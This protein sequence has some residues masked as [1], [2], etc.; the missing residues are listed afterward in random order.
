MLRPIRMKKVHAIV[1]ED[2]L[3]PLMRELKELGIIH[4]INVHEEI[5][6]QEMLK[7]IGIEVPPSTWVRYKTSGLL[8][9]INRILDIL[10]SV[11][12][13]KTF[14]NKIKKILE[15]KEIEKIPIKETS[16]LELF[17]GFE[18]KFEN[19]EKEVLKT[20]SKLD[21][22]REERSDILTCQEVLSILE[23]FGIGPKYLEGF[24]L[25]YLETGTVPKDQLN[26]LEP[27]LKEATE[28]FLYL[29]SG[30]VDKKTKF[31]II[32][33]LYE[34]E[35][36][37]RKILRARGFES[38]SIPRKICDLE[39]ED[40]E[41]FLEESISHI[42]VE[43]DKLKEELKRIANVNEKELL[44]MK[45][46]LEIE[47]NLDEI[48]SLFGK[49]TK[50]Y[51]I[52][53]WVP[54][55]L[56]EKLKEIFNNITNGY[57]IIRIDEPKK[58]DN[59]PT[60]LSNPPPIKPVEI[61]TETYGL[62]GYDK[63]DPTFFM[64]ISFPFMYGLMFGDVG[65]GLVIAILGFLLGFYFKFGEV[66][67]KFGKIMLACGIMGTL[68]GL[69]YGSVF[70]LEI[71]E[72]L[73]LR[74][75]ESGTNLV[76][77]AIVIGLVQLSLGI[78][79]NMLNHIMHKD[80][81]EALFPPWSLSGLWLLWGGTLLIIKHGTDVF[82]LLRDTL[83]IP[84]LY[85][86]LLVICIGTKYAEHTSFLWGFY[87]SFEA[88]T[89]YLANCISYVRITAI[90]LV[91]AALCSI[92]VMFMEMVAPLFLKS[93]VFL[94]GNI[95]IIGIEGFVSFI[96]TLRLHYY[97]WFSKFYDAGGTKFEAFKAIRKYTFLAPL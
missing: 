66:I 55:Y 5:E 23:N 11:E 38:L 75:L 27:E 9:R 86:P 79:L 97:E 94:I 30:D 68:G 37:I 85:L 84:F 81:L 96:Q 71:L 48:T 64:G 7:E 42:T 58:G 90:A 57:G 63:I 61:L 50:S 21:A 10:Q 56:I 35:S 67:E 22:L 70:G 93:I 6:S 53:G 26:F 3:D 19:I 47:K 34:Y 16:I 72:P 24:K 2:K 89:R 33:S 39:L 49:T 1:L 32:V 20:S 80:Y 82:L 91:H 95:F 69:L 77:F 62:P 52:S 4:L 36:E 83:A 12:E 54:Y 41:N 74:P 8:S 46:Q 40:A 17:E 28:D 88:I 51:L 78:I 59:P 73:W 31:I 15:V 13:E 25:F 44:L 14:S 92:M 60:M 18:K 65:Q 29:F 87:G 76:V 45:E 43:E